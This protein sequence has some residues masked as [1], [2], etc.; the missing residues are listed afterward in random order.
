MK[1]D[2][3]GMKIVPET[4]GALDLAREIILVAMTREGL[5]GAGNR[6]PWKVPQELKL[7]RRLT[8]GGTVVMGRKTF[9]SLGRPLDQR[10]NI[11]VSTTLSETPGITLCRDFPSAVAAAAQIGGKVYYIGGREIYRLALER[12]ELLRISWISGSYAGDRYFPDF[13]RNRWRLATSKDYVVF[14]HE[15]H[16]RVA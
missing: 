15:C 6:I 3:T 1:G 2:A 4:T 12:A 9:E 8:L 10:R 16:L 14:V 5:I 11:V 13:D 7:F